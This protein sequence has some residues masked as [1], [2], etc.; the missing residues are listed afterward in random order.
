MLKKPLN[1]R[2]LWVGYQLCCEDQ[3]PIKYDGSAVIKDV[4]FPLIEICSDGTATSETDL[5]AS[6]YM[7]TLYIWRLKLVERVTSFR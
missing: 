3:A 5:I 6:Y 7:I 1:L 2:S 4:L